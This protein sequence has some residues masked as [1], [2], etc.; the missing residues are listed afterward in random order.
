MNTEIARYSECMCLLTL[1]VDF[2]A[3]NPNT[4]SAQPHFDIPGDDFSI[5]A[6]TINHGYANRCLMIPVLSQR[7]RLSRGEE[8]LHEIFLRVKA[9]IQSE[10]PSQVPEY[11]TTMSRKFCLHKLFQPK[12]AT[13]KHRLGNCL[14]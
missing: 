10:E 3:R 13:S 11:R 7:L 2:D 1:F 8:D 12:A 5:L 14:K 6:A 9:D 4:S